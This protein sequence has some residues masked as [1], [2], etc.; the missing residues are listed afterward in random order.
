MAFE[1]M[2]NEKFTTTGLLDGGGEGRG[3]G[4]ARA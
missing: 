4:Q 3:G 2:W 1:P